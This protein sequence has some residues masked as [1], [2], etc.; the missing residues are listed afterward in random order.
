MEINRVQYLEIGSNR[1]VYLGDWVSITHIDHIFKYTVKK[2]G[3]VYDMGNDY[4]ILDTSDKDDIRKCREMIRFESI[5]DISTYKEIKVEKQKVNYN[6][7]VLE[8]TRMYT[9]GK[10]YLVILHDGRRYYGE[11]IRG[12]FSGLVICDIKRGYVE[13]PLD[14][15]QRGYGHPELNTIKGGIK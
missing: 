13:I 3:I 6:G 8:E 2:E 4:L 5:T 15:I 1:R 7:F 10:S 11:C 12:N 9:K 14:S